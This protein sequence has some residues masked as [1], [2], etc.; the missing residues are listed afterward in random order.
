MA[1]YYSYFLALQVPYLDW[2][3]DYQILAGGIYSS[4]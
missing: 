3:R 4:L 2:Q 1:T